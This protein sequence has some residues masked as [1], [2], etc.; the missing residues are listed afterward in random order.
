MQQGVILGAFWY[1]YVVLQIP[2]GYVAERYGGKSVFAIGTAVSVVATLLS[3]MMAKIYR[4]LFI[5]LQVIS[6][7]GQVWFS[8]F[9]IYISTVQKLLSK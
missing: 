5:I 3:P 1:G 7:L 9:C 8:Q 4:P 2:A 6:G